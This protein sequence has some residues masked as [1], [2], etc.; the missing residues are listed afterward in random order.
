MRWLAVLLVPFFV[1]LALRW[2][3]PPS[4]TSGDYAQYLSHARAL[5]EGRPY[6]DIGYIFQP[7]ASLIGPR[8]YP[9]GLAVTLAPVVALGGVHSPLVRLLMLAC[10]VL[11][12]TLAGA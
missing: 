5:V 11:F 8:N 12:V 1:L 3:W 2:N 7:A 9:P 4:A 6:S 10:V